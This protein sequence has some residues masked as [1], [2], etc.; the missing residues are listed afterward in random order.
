[1]SDVRGALQL[2]AR[3]AYFAFDLLWLD[4]EDLR[5]LPLLERKQRLQREKLGDRLMRKARKLHRRL[6]GEGND[7]TCPPR[8]PLRMRQRTYERLMARWEQA[9]EQADYAWSMEILRRFGG[10]R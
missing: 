3:L 10:Y 8:K 4:G 2:P 5:G 1:M 6:G 7:Y 9:A